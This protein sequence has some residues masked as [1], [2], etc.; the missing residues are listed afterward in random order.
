MGAYC[1]VLPTSCVYLKLSRIKHEQSYWVLS[2]LSSPICFA[3]D[4][5]YRAGRVACDCST[6]TEA[7]A[8]KED[9]LYVGRLGFLAQL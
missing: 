1:T 5:L 3:I 4:V 8:W 2:L 6:T 9:V 7:S